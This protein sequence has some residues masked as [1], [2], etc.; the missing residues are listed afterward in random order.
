MN[1]GTQFYPTP[2][3]VI[4]TMAKGH[5]LNRGMNILDPSAGKGDLL[6]G[7]QEIAN[8]GQRELHESYY[9]KTGRWVGG[10]YNVK[11]N[12]YAIEID[13]ILSGFLTTI[14]GIDLIDKDFLQ[15]HG[16]RKFDYIFMNPPFANGD[17]HL[18]HAWEIARGAT[19]VCLLNAETIKNPYSQ[20]RKELQNIISAY[21]EVEFL[22]DV[23][24]DA[25]APTGVNVAM[26]TLVH[27]GGGEFDFEY[28]PEKEFHVNLDD[29]P[30]GELV[31]ANQLV[32]FEQQ[33]NAGL[34][35]IREAISAIE[36]AG[37][38]LEPLTGQS[39][40]D[41]FSNV[42]RFDSAQGTYEKLATE[43]NRKAWESVFRKTKLSTLVTSQVRDELERMETGIGKMAYTAG[44][45][46]SLFETLFLSRDKLARA[47]ILE[48]FDL[49]TKYH[50]ENRVSV[51][52]WKTNASYFV[53][54]KVILP[55]ARSDYSDGLKSSMIDKLH[56]IEKSL[57][58]M[59]GEKFQ[60][61][62]TVTAAFGESFVYGEWYPSRF[63]DAKLYKKG[64]IHLR[65]VSEDVR[66]QFNKIV[67]EERYGGLPE[68]VKTGAYA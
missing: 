57:C 36:K 7:I 26:V 5:P 33:Y 67:A 62:K 58:I 2:K 64:T 27:P 40:I 14:D 19:I 21:G 46:E 49:M 68:K 42:D 61:V 12:K 65:W 55:Y 11:L 53:G 3:S 22:G 32:A 34:S 60:D 66:Q 16:F 20:R 1:V 54:K 50:A 31:S 29:I 35:A 37:H 45:M 13:P 6:I 24:K 39:G 44:N 9:K 23:F 4:E 8:S 47:S 63:F 41:F 59:I 51:E 17:A 18:L 56:D 25:E 52:G 43:V 28:K 48:A 38:Y 15:Y 30:T 10:D